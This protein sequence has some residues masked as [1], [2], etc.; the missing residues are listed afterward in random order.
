[1]E[2]EKAY[3]FAVSMRRSE[4]RRPQTF[5]RVDDSDCSAT[6]VNGIVIV[7]R[8]YPGT[9]ESTTEEQ[10]LITPTVVLAYE[11]R[12]DNR[13]EIAYALGQPRLA[14]QPDGAVLAAAYDAWGHKLSAK[15]V[16]EYAYVIFDRRTQQFVAGQDSLGVRRLFYFTI[17]ER[18]LIT[19][20]LRLL[21]QRFPEARPSYSRE[22]LREYFTGT[23]SPW[24]GRTIWRGIYELKRGNVLVQRGSELEEQTAWQPD[25][26]R[27][28]RF[29]SP[30]EV[31]E[32]FRRLLFDAV[33]A[34]L[35]ASGP[36]LCD[37]SGGYDSSTICSVAALLTQAG[38]SRG[39][40]IGWSMVSKRS[41]E[42]SFQDEVRRQYQI[43]SHTLDLDRH[44][45]FQ[46]F[47]DTEI[48]AGG[49]V[50]GAI[51]RAMGEFARA[52]GIRTHLTGHGA[53]MLFSKSGGGAPVYLA[54]WLREGRFRDWMRHFVAYLRGGSF[55]A[56]HLLRDCTV[57]T[58]DLHSGF[59][60]PIPDWV[61]SIF[62]K[63]IK[64][65][66]D[67]F[68]HGR[69]RAFRSDARERVY[70]W[71]LC[72]LPYNRSLPDERVPFAYRPLVEFILG[73]DWDHIVRPNEERLLMRRGL[74]GI[75]PEAVRTGG[76]QIAFSA[77]LL[78]GLRAAWPR[79]SHFVTGDQLAE[80]GVVER[81]PFQTALEAMRA[82]YL[83]PNKQFAITALYLETWLGLKACQAA[84]G[85]RLDVIPAQQCERIV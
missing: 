84:S 25:P 71:T 55:N 39:P 23:M 85:A 29:K 12:V 82:G 26:D 57:G 5:R 63:E 21:F 66:N 65:A 14:H 51:Y 20:N 75:L 45:P 8:H 33:R 50:S 9:P 60:E 41:N 31:D 74:R 27:R 62:R 53:D 47:T 11:G 34:A 2:Y 59:R 73:L 22:V 67:E 78:E 64:Q 56:W 70:R 28:E 35:R 16:G 76:C 77:A 69:P 49:F 38:D 19:S 18:V 30:D 24:S 81:K 17:G 48:P 3:G 36:V 83:G 13:E 46:S 79:I 68:L 80:L 52:R 32:V 58:L 6:T 1:M 44:L 40:I 15:T 61:T 37:L 7:V 10:P 4:L 43:E 42:S 72:F 54:E